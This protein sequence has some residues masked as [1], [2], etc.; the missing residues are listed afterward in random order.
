MLLGGENFIGRFV[1][2]RSCRSHGMFEERWLQRLEALAQAL[3]FYK[4]MRCAHSGT[5]T[6]AE[7]PVNNDSVRIR[8]GGYNALYIEWQ[9]RPSASVLMAGGR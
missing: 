6:P 2:K 7:F 5:F 9:N 3:E 8:R 4:I 1:D